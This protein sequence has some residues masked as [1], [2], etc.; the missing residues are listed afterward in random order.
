MVKEDLFSGIRACLLKFIKN[1]KTLV[2][3][4]NMLLKFGRSK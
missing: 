2:K 4:N 3:K 1:H